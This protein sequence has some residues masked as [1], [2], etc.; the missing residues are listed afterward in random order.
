M[1]VLIA[2]DGSP[3]ART[4]LQSALQ[5]L[6]PADRNLDILCVVPPY[7]R[8]GE[9]SSRERYDKLALSETTKILEQARCAIAPDATTVQVL[10]EIGSPAVVIAEKTDDYD[11]T[12][13]GARGAGFRSEAGLGPVASRV[14]EHAGGP[15]LVGRAL[16]SEEGLR[17]LAAVDGSDASFRAVETVGTL[18]DLSLAEVCLMYVA[19]TPWLNLASE[20]DFAT[21]SEEEMERSEPGVL[22]KEFVREGESVVERARRLLSTSQVPGS[23]QAQVTTRM[24]EGNPASEILAEAERGQYDL[25]AVGAT[26]NRDVKHRMLGSVSL[27]LAWEAPCSV[28]VVREPGETR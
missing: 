6:N 18:C 16:R 14:V 15:V 19:E 10:A 2:T 8:K 3:L 27:R 28:L 4:A 23:S 13:I 12:V 25:I 24:L 1:K 11:L 5:L 20:G 21:A 17:I 9:T 7:S 26:G 22:E